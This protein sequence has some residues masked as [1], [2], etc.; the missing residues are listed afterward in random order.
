MPLHPPKVELY[1]SNRPPSPGSTRRAAAAAD[2]T[3]A[4][5]VSPKGTE[6]TAPGG[7]K[8]SPKGADGAAPEPVKPPLP[9]PLPPVTVESVLR[10]KDYYAVLGVRRS[11]TAA[12]AAESQEGKSRFSV[13]YKQAALRC[14]PDKCGDDPKAVEAFIKV[15]EAYQVLSNAELRRA[16]N[17]QLKMAEVFG[18]RGGGKKAGET[19]VDMRSEAE[20]REAQQ[21]EFEKR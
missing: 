9:P 21:R 18:S 4:T 11:P 2:S 14:H 17:A 7:G 1:A 12:E 16:Y 5:K 19:H 3:G 15:K 10:A 20:R 6:S 13:A 8:G